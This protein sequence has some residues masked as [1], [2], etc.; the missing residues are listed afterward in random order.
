M[1]FEL[2]KFGPNSRSLMSNKLKQYRLDVE[3]IQKDLVFSY[4]NLKLFGV[5]FYLNL[6]I[7]KSSSRS[8]QIC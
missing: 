8:K 3:L 7:E 6:K 2:S 1:E 4:C 5:I